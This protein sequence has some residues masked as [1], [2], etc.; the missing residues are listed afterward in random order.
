MPIVFSR[1]RPKSSRPVLLNRPGHRK[2]PVLHER[3]GPV[4]PAD[5]ASFP[6][7]F[8]C[9]IGF[10]CKREQGNALFLCI[11]TVYIHGCNEKCCERTVVG[12]F[13]GEA[14]EV[15]EPV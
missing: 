13:P 14:R 5:Q 11:F 6:G 2:F 4:S 3:N 7:P 1:S 8:Q 12:P 10:L 9:S 15:D